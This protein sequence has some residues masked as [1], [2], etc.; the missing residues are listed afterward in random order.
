MTR[1]SW[2]REKIG[3]SKAARKLSSKKIKEKPFFA[4][5]TSLLLKLKNCNSSCLLKSSFLRSL[6]KQLSYPSIFVLSFLLMLN[7]FSWNVRGLND[8]HKHCLVKSVISKLHRSVVCLQESKVDFVSHFFFRSC[9]E[10]N[11]DKYHFL[12]TIGAFGGLITCWDSNHF[13]YAE[14]IMR[15]HSLTLLLTYLTSGKTFFLTNVYGPLSW[16]GK[17]EFCSKL[18]SF[19][20]SCSNN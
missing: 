4:A 15:K 3:Q 9:C 19:K 5:S 14:V 13:R 1:K 11:F 8:S 18:L 10:S 6:G 7:I 12:P 20:N 2:L 16:D 17:G